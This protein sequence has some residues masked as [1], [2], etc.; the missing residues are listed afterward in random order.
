MV[1]WAILL[2]EGVKIM[3]ERMRILFIDEYNKFFTVKTFLCDGQIES[4]PKCINILSEK[5]ESSK[6]GVSIS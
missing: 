5:L 1:F 6:N 4:E 2:N 3:C